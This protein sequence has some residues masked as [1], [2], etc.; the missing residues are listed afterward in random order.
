MIQA[1]S[2]RRRSRASRP[3]GAPRA[4][5][6]K[7]G[8][9]LLPLGAVWLAM[10]MVTLVGGAVL[11]PLGVIALAVSAAVLLAAVA[12]AP[13]VARL[14]TL[15]WPV[16]A[17]LAA[18]VLL[19]LLQIVPLPP[20]IWHALPGQ[21][22]RRAV[23]ATIGQADMWQP[24]SLM[25]LYTIEAA[26]AC[27]MFAALVAA[28]LLLSD[29]HLRKAGWLVFAIVL[30]DVAIGTLQVSSGG[31]PIVRES[32][33][34]GAMLG[35][36]ANKNHMGL[37]VAASMPLAWFLFDVRLRRSVS[38]YLFLGWCALAIVA[39]AATNS[40]SGLA[41]G[42]VAIGALGL[43]LLSKR[44]LRLRLS[45]LAIAVAAGAVISFTD[46]FDALFGR[47]AE[48]DDDLR[49]R[50]W[51]QSLPLLRVYWPLGSGA[52]SFTQLFVVHEQLLWVKP[53]IVNA[54]HNDYLQLVIEFGVPGVVVALLFVTALLS[55]AMAHPRFAANGSIG[56]G[57][58]T[59][60]TIILLFALQSVVD[61]PLR[62]V[63]TLPMFAIATV[64]IL[65]AALARAQDR[66]AAATLP[67]AGAVERLPNQNELGRRESSC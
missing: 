59:G 32:R 12:S 51:A 28:M 56:I 64:L 46:P 62:R 29:S 45:L 20:A 53:T 44:S 40:R 17:A 43:Q 50:F 2:S 67:V 41:V 60:I 37:F 52:G 21:E 57:V 42:M 35:F 36:F 49:W 16:Q 8:R 65:R 22:V 24:I 10:V 61:Y 55:S 30:I 15:P 34:Q 18:I 33:N 54:V 39:L 4:W 47:F 58:R 5:I 63:A 23:L 9:D 13:D 25:P 66:E 31:Y 27:M 11:T 14:A 3:G 6:F 1:T 19:P 7:K 26:V 48:V 38:L